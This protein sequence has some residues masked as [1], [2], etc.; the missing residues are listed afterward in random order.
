MREKWSDDLAHAPYYQLT[1]QIGVGI[2]TK[3][4][5]LQGTTET[6]EDAKKGMMSWYNMIRILLQLPS[7]FRNGKLEK[8]DQP[9]KIPMRIV[10]ST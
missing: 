5:Q 8:I 3:I 7:S 9:T 10:H 1:C 6:I 2:Y 4:G